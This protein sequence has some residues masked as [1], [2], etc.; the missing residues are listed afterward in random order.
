MNIDLINKYLEEN[1]KYTALE[2]FNF[3][4][5][6]NEIVR[7]NSKDYKLPKYKEKVNINA[8]FIYA[9]G[10]FKNLNEEYA[11]YFREKLLDETFYVSDNFFTANSYYDYELCK[12]VIEIPYTKTI[13]DAYTIVH[14]T[15]HDMNQQANNSQF[16]RKIITESISMLGEMLFEKF[17]I[18]NKILTRDNHKPII[19]NFKVVKQTSD[20]VNLELDLIDTYKTQGYVDFKTVNKLY[21]KYSTQTIEEFIENEYTF[22]IDFNGRYILGILISCYMYER[23]NKKSKLIN[24]FF[25]INNN[26]NNMCIEDIFTY[27]NLDVKTDEA[28]RILFT[29]E[30]LNT[31][32]KTY[33]KVLK[34]L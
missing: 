12:N 5:Q 10:F 21:Q 15:L 9:Y 29:D 34:G 8:S 2:N 13:L 25:D 11:E 32:E 4:R 7:R 17:L 3:I 1:L 24:E 27:L 22:Q 31:L 6:I 26:M 28:Q 33:K 16:S 19:S 23:I 20:S 30:S 18:E 14:E